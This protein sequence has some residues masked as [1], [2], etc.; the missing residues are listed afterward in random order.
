MQ[1]AARAQDAT[2][3]FRENYR[4]GQ[5]FNVLFSE[6][7]QV[8]AM[9]YAQGTKVSTIESVEASQDKGVLKVLKTADGT[10]V[11]EQIALDPSCGQF[12][13]RSGQSPKQ[14]YTTYAGKSVTVRREPTG[15]VSAEV[16]GRSEPKLAVQLRNWLE[17][18]STLYPDHPVHVKEK[19]DLSKKLAHLINTRHGEQI[20]AFCQLR[21]VKTVKGR[22]FAELGIS[23][24]MIGTMYGLQ[25][26]N[27]IEGSAWVDLATGRVAK[28]DLTG[29]MH[30]SGNGAVHLSDG[31]FIAT[32]AVGDGKYEYHQLCVAAK[33]RSDTIASDG[34]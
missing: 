26:E 34:N 17:R 19:W 16:D 5:Q 2:Y 24:G 21:S 3:E 13:Q 7:T 9:L 12:V 6:N 20:T 1:V 18:D 10:P 11:A 32:S 23:C 33:V 27:Q 28:M 4:E 29:D 31:R 25:V 30:V 14:T 15:G 8:K 22:D